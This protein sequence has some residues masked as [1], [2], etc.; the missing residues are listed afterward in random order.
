[1]VPFE[2]PLLVPQFVSEFAPSYEII[3]GSDS[4]GQWKLP[5]CELRPGSGEIAAKVAIAKTYLTQIRIA[6]E[7]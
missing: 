3:Q 1:M 5:K 4:L 2:M 7:R 6:D